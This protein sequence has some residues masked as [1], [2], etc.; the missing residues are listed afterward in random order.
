AGTAMRGSTAAAASGMPVARPATVPKNAAF[1]PGL[2]FSHPEEVIARQTATAVT[3]NT[4]GFIRRKRYRIVL[5]VDKHKTRICQGRRSLRR[6]TVSAAPS[7]RG[8][9]SP[10][11]SFKIPLTG[12]G[13]LRSAGQPA[14]ERH[15]V[16]KH[17]HGVALRR[18]ILP[19][20]ESLIAVD[21]HAK[22]VNVHNAQVCLGVQEAHL[23]RPCE[24]AKGFAYIR[25]QKT[26][27]ALL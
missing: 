25:I 8:G 23:L 27:D 10:F 26:G 11:C 20:T 2:R 21:R 19:E 18:T 16:E 13:S 5:G 17:V 1:S 15:G 14:F 12:L 9:V 22:T 6:G 3:G 7:R 24:E 4:L